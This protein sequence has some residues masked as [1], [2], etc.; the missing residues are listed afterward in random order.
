MNKTIKF[1]ILVIVILFLSLYF[2]NYN[3]SYYENKYNLTEKAIKNY[4]E[5][6]KS[7]KPIIPSNYLQEE[8]NYNNKISNVGIKVSKL[9]EKA[10]TDGINNIIKLLEKSQKR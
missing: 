9:I 3:N 10:F 6:L 5:D 1:I 2:S 4:E 8:K 7:G